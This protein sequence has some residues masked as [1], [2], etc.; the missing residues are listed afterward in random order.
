MPRR[1]RPTSGSSA[2]PPTSAC[3]DLGGGHLDLHPEELTANP[4]DVLYPDRP[5]SSGRH[6]GQVVASGIYDRLHRRARPLHNLEH[7]YVNVLYNPE[8]QR[9]QVAE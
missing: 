2:A 7:G 3:P 4:P 9:T 1:W 8:R 5:P 6:F